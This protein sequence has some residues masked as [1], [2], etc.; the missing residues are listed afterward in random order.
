MSMK[1]CANGSTS[2][3][4]PQTP[5]FWNQPKDIP[6]RRTSSTG[7]RSGIKPNE[8]ACGFSKVTTLKEAEFT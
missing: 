8:A 7:T 4:P 6:V 3:K 1:E 2:T 5:S